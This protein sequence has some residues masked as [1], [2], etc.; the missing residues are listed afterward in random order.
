MKKKCVG[1]CIALCAC[2]NITVPPAYKYVEIQTST[3]KLASWQKI[4]QQN[5]PYKFYIEGDGSAFRSDGSVSSDPTPRSTLLRE[6]AFGDNQSNIIYL[7]RPCQYVQDN[8]CEAKYWST[9]RFST[10]AV[11]AEYEAI[12]SIAGEQSVTLVGFSGGAQIA[13]LIAVKYK[14]IKIQKLV[15]IAGN[16]DVKSWT[17]YHEVPTLFLSDDLAN[18]KT[19]YAKF[20]Q[21]HYVGLQDENIIP[22]ITEN[23]VTDK[24]TIQYIKK[25]SHNK[26]WKASYNSIRSE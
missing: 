21:I 24:N 4:E 3:F 15:T 17:D 11:N 5:K 16:L 6:I 14:D 2:N 18:Y 20:N 8:M 26:G 12:K 9:A 22:Q 23:F 13:G 7:A 25:A 1:L 10:E 19:D